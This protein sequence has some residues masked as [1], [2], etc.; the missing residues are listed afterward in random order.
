M[1]S[2]TSC[3]GTSVETV[4]LPKSSTRQLSSIVPFRAAAGVTAAI[5]M[6]QLVLAGREFVCPQ[7]DRESASSAAASAATESSEAH[8]GQH[9]PG[10]SSEPS[11][12][13][14]MPD[15][16]P[17]M[18]A[19]SSSVALRSAASLLTGGISP[20]SAPVYVATLVH[21]RVES[22]DPPPPKA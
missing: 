14:P 7:H 9:D 17:A 15:C 19:C 1:N 10:K 11:Q 2:S 3:I 5:F 6:F 20:S 8:H 12:H 18:G 22:P 4:A 16:C 13:H 21:S